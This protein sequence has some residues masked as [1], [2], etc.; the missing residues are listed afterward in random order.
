MLA[1]GTA[2]APAG[3]VVSHQQLQLPRALDPRHT[4]APAIS[5]AEEG[6]RVR[7]LMGATLP[8]SEGR[9]LLVQVGWGV[10]LT[11]THHHPGQAML[12]VISNVQMKAGGT[13]MMG[14]LT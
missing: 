4:H 8:Q 9:G 6:R 10:R 14:V 3:H 5:E 2:W 12:V 7:R 1:Q 13:H 11:A